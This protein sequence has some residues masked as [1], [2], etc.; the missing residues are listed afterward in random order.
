MLRSLAVFVTT[1]LP[2][3]QSVTIEADT[4]AADLS[5]FS[6]ISGPPA[7]LDA[8]SG[9]ELAQVDMIKDY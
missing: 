2:A 6:Q 4:H 3:L 8:Y 7:A 5:D 1:L 9:T